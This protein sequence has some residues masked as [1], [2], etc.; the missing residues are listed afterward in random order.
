MGGTH[1]IKVGYQYN[2]LTNVINQTATIPLCECERRPV[3]YGYGSSAVILAAASA[4][5]GSEPMGSCAGQYGYVTN[6]ISQPS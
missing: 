6:S 1:N 5:S 2:R 3:G 4:P